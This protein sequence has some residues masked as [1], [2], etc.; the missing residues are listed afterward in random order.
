M[1]S[2]FEELFS[3]MDSVGERLA[4]LTELAQKK[5]DAVL[6]DD[7]LTLNEIMNQEQAES[8]AFRSLESRREKLL[9]ELGIGNTSL[10]A[11]AQLCPADQR[12]RA[13]ECAA[14]VQKQYKQYRTTSDA[15]RNVLEK[16]IREID[17]VLQAAGA[18]A[19][20]GAPGYVEQDAV[21]PAN[22]KTDF[23]A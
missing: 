20:S 18:H 17:Q 12:A 14:S 21:L 8:L 4:Q 5:H 3:L 2:L 10:S 11:L 6:Q 16:G 1:D 9:K 23:H 7:L 22:M 13:A 15:T 19:V